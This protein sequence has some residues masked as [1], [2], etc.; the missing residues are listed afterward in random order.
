MSDIGLI[1]LLVIIA[2][3]IAVGLLTGIAALFEEIVE[4]GTGK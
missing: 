3:F 1:A 2:S 4:E